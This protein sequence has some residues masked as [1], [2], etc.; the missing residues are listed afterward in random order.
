VVLEGFRIDA[1]S[2]IIR[3][4]RDQIAPAIASPKGFTRTLEEAKAELAANWRK[5]LAYAGLKD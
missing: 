2:L 4:Q 3:L 5:W 1:M